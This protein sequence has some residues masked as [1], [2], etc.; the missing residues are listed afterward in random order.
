MASRSINDLVAPA[1]SLAPAARTASANGTGVDLHGHEAAEVLIV[2]GVITDGSHAVTIEESDDDSTY[3][4]VAAAD[5]IGT[6]PT[7]T[8][9][10]GGSAV[11]KLAYLGGKRYLRVVITASGT[12]SGGVIGAIVVRGRRHVM[13]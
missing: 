9:S 12:T 3:T 6:L 4:A 2:A 1:I 8:S 5:R 10:S 13:P 7:L 11:H